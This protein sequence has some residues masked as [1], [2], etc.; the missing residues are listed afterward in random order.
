MQLGRLPSFPIRKSSTGIC[1]PGVYS[2]VEILDHYWDWHMLSSSVLLLYSMCLRIY[3][4]LYTTK[5]CS[6]SG[7]SSYPY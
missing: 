5:C 1:S 3:V 4:V 6:K 2:S 7:S